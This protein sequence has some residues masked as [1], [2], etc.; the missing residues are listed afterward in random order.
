[1]IILNFPKGMEG[2]R[3]SGNVRRGFLVAVWHNTICSMVQLFCPI[4]F[5]KIAGGMCHRIW[6]H[7]CCDIALHPHCFV[8]YLL[9][10]KILLQHMAFHY[11]QHNE[12]S[13]VYWSHKPHASWAVVNL[14][15]K[16]SAFS[17]KEC[18]QGPSPHPL[19]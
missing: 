1:M 19:L 5:F 18:E 2:R 13:A 6:W 8:R 16:Y 11:G 7:A 4:W 9:A 17:E 15:G 3:D 14:S 12:L 10:L